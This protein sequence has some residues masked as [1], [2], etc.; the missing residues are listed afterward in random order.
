[1]HNVDWNYASF[2]ELIERRQFSSQVALMAKP[3]RALIDLVALRKLQW[4]GLAFLIE[5]LRIEEQTLKE[6]QRADIEALVGV[7]KQKRPNTFLASLA[8][9]LDLD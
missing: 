3:L 8:R 5:G 6:I 4:Q 2:L 7:Y 9:E 1:L